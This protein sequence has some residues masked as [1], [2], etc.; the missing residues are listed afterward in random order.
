MT[1]CPEILP[2]DSELDGDGRLAV[3]GCSVD[4]LAAEHG[5]PLMAG[6]ERDLREGARGFLEAVRSRHPRSDVY[7]ASKALPSPAVIG[8]FAEEGLGCDVA[9][10]GELAFAEA[11]G[12]PAERMLLHGNAKTDRDL[13]AA[14]AAGIGLI[15]V[16]SLDEIDRLER[17][18]PESQAVLLRVNPGVGAPTHA[19]MNTGDSASK[20]GLEGDDLGR[21]I[22]RLE[23]S[24][25]LELE[26]L[27]V[28]IG[29]QIAQLEPFVEGVNRLISV[30][31]F[32]TFDFGGG[33]GVRYL[34]EESPYPTVDDFAAM[35]VSTAQRQLGTDFR[36]IVE[37][38][39]CLVARAIVTLYRVVG[40]KHGAERVF[41]SVD[42]GMGDN[43]EPRLYA[44]KFAPFIAGSDRE[45]V[46][47]DIVGPHCETGDRLREHYPLSGPRIDDLLV[48]P[49]TGAYCASLANNYN[50]MG[51]PAMVLCENGHARL[52]TRRETTEDMLR[53]HITS[54]P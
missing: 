20:F 40:V 43:L 45:E 26:G 14:I 18:V 15:V 16:D 48:V 1:P 19:S 35:V 5:T 12:M 38:G 41:V 23:A 49:V 4:E 36:L 34:P 54:P 13:E 25:R 30:G 28:H 39:R 8:I 50:A 10:A 22:E 7:F 21:A 9:S 53:R 33:L 11:G 2:V 42:G 46:I 47:C 24:G 44:Q 27:H 32:P 37:P 31:A 17:L 52:A 3:G 29:S 51:R 6:S